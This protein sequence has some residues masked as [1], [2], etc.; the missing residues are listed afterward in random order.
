MKL[1]APD[2]PAHFTFDDAALVA[3][4]RSRIMGDS[5]HILRRAGASPAFV[6]TS[7]PAYEN[8]LHLAIM[9]PDGTLEIDVD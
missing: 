6:I 8:T 3:A 9:R 5:F 4:R 1:L 7:A 2:Y